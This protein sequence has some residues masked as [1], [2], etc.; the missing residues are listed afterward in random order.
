MGLLAVIGG[1]VVAK[2]IWLEK[3]IVLECLLAKC[4]DGL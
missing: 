3:P 1:I 2:A 4:D